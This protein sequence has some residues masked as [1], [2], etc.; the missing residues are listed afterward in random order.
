MAV[1]E[2]VNEMATQYVDQFIVGN[3][4]KHK[5]FNEEDISIFE[6][7]ARDALTDLEAVHL[8]NRF[9]EIIEIENGYT[10]EAKD[11]VKNLIINSKISLNNI[12]EPVVILNSK[13]N[14]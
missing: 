14:L 10:T 12:G 8:R 6:T 13:F 1:R 9:I 3:Y 5:I 11:K 4:P 7:I 2:K